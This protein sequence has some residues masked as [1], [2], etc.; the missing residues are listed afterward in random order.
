[1]LRKPT[2]GVLLAVALAALATPA[3]AQA[4][5]PATQ[6]HWG[7]CSRQTTNV[8]EAVR[9]YAA[10]GVLADFARLVGIPGSGRVLVG[11]MGRQLVV[12]RV[13][14]TVVTANHGCDGAG[15][16]FAVGPRTLKASEQVGVRVPPK[17]RSRLCVRAHRG[18]RRIVLKESVV[19]P[20][21][22]WNPNMGSVSVVLYVHRRKP[23]RHV[24]P[25]KE[26]A[27]PPAPP[28]KP[29]PPPPSPPAPPAPV[30]DP[31]ATVAQQS[32]VEGA[33]VVVT[34]SDGATATASA[35]FVVN[36]T[37]YGPVE[38]G[39]SQQV[40]I[41]LASPGTEVSLTVTSGSTTLISGESFKNSCVAKPSATVLSDQCKF[42]EDM[43]FAEA[44]IELSN[45]AT[46]TLPAAFEVEWTSPAE[47]LETKEYGPLAPGGTETITL[48][49]IAAPSEVTVRS[50][51]Q[52]LM[53][54]ELSSVCA[55]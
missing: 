23:K 5:N 7:A 35:S 26:K 27:L 55:E 41:P 21:T 22:C 11:R 38:P 51:G 18:C 47:T 42:E 1:M 3:A 54:E 44:K 15:D 53:K 48:S 39:K 28:A 19:F 29:T 33:G 50:G 25:A 40:T 14:H 31:A 17:L 36:G 24:K 34:L 37:T 52:V 46:A 10:N 4:Y 45:A 12:A 13:Q 2:H 30:A 43:V 6:S 20:I 32:C 9:D 49:L 8:S 16:W